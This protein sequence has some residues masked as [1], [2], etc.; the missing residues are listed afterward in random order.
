MEIMRRGPSVAVAGFLV[1]ELAYILY[2]TAPDL[3]PSPG[4]YPGSV[5]VCVLR[6]FPWLWMGLATL[7]LLNAAAV[8]LRTR[9][10]ITLGFLTQAILLLGLARNMSQEIGW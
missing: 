9:L 7:L 2:A 5:D 8:L 4:C 3:N 6:P 1:V 10:S